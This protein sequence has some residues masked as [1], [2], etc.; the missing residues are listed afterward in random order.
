MMRCLVRPLA[1]CVA[2]A[3][4]AVS[5]ALPA[6]D[7]EAAPVISPDRL[8]DVTA[9]GSI[10]WVADDDAELLGQLEARLPF[11]LSARSRLFLDISTQ[12]VLSEG[13]GD[14]TF[15]VDRLNY[16]ANFGADLRLSGRRVSFFAGQQGQE[17]VDTEGSGYVRYVGAG[18]RS[19][20]DRGEGLY[21]SVDF[22]VVIAE[23]AVTADA[24]LRAA[25]RYDPGAWK[26]FGLDFESDGLIDGGSLDADVRLGPHYLWKF[27]QRYQIAVYA[28]YMRSRNPLGVG[29]DSA[30]VGLDITQ[31][32]TGEGS[33]ISPPDISGVVALGGGGG[34]AA[35]RLALFFALPVFWG[36]WFEIDVDTNVLTGEDVD[37]LYY[38]YNIGYER[39]V[40]S[41]IGG[42]Y[43]YHR[44]NHVIDADARVRSIN[45]IDVGIET[46]GFSKLAVDTPTGGWGRLDGGVRLGGF[47]SSSFGDT[48]DWHALGLMRWVAPWRWGP[49]RPLVAIELAGGGVE[50][51]SVAV[52]VEGALGLGLDLQY[53]Q[54]DQWFGADDTAV[55]LTGRR[56]F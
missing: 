1:L 52:G 54:D 29:F 39:P 15:A 14:F 10:A 38:L 48:P 47:L 24:W 26:G 16:V 30:L 43:F 37:N 27:A 11:P 42:V 28:H 41:F 50:R 53:V 6:D 56:R 3:V 51:R 13:V 21:W 33:R 35:A 32:P 8:D 34:R 19:L 49:L 45:V 36:G 22:G 18:T 9:T 23:R 17:R 46:E 2:L 25:L 55:L 7:P 31:L 4:C 44:S 40:A 12:S 20:D 5:P